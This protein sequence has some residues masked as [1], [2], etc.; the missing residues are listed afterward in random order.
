MACIV[1]R[2]AFPVNLTFPQ[3]EASWAVP[4][5]DAL[6]PEV[7]HPVPGGDR[8]GDHVAGLRSAVRMTLILRGAP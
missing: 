5:D 4:Y 6:G 1:D 2:R 7:Q 3:H 8:R